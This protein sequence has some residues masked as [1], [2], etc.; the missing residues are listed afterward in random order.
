MSRDR[1]PTPTL[2]LGMPNERKLKSVTSF[3]ECG[4]YKYYVHEYRSFLC[5]N[6]AGCAKSKVQLIQKK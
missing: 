4:C 2:K 6:Q 3:L 5:I 1:K